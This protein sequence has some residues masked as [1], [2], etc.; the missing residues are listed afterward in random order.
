[1]IGLDDLIVIKRTLGRP[2]D[3]DSLQYLLV[4]KEILERRQSEPSDT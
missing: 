3:L 4:V 1:V 2:K